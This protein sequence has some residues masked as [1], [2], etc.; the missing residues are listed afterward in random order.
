MYLFNSLAKSCT[1]YENTLKPWTE[2]NTKKTNDGIFSNK[3]EEN[4]N[5]AKIFL[6]ISDFK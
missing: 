4:F 6:N 1:L 5:F 2:I 3:A